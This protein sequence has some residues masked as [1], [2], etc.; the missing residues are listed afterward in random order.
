MSVKFY[1]EGGGHGGLSRP[2]CREAFTEYFRKS[3]QA[4]RSPRVVVCGSRNEAFSRFKTAVENRPSGEIF[5]LLVDSESPVINSSPVAHLHQQDGWIFAPLGPDKVFLMVQAME[6]WFLAD[7]TVLAT[8]YGSNFISGPLPG[9]PTN[10]ETI[11]KDDLE[12]RLKQASKNCQKGAYKKVKHGFA[13]LALV[14]PAKV[15]IGS[16]HAKQLNAFLR[17]L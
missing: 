15:E 14:S 5:A 17:S 12:P 6:A 2:M 3:T 4:G 10:I 1:V 8:F 11:P 13:L 7:T 9:S 16:A